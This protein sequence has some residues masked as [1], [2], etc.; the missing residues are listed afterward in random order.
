[1]LRRLTA[2]VVLFSG[3]AM[4]GAG[5]FMEARQADPAQLAFEDARRIEV[6]DRDLRG[7]IMKYRDVVTRYASNRAVAAIALVRLAACYQQLGQPEATA[8]LQRVV[9]DFADQPTAV[10]AARAAMSAARPAVAAQTTVARRVVYEDS[11]WNPVAVSPD[12]RFAVGRA[13]GVRPL[14]LRTLPARDDRPLF[15]QSETSGIAGAPVFSRD[16]GMAAFIWVERQGDVQSTSIGVIGTSPNAVPRRITPAVAGNVNRVYPVAWSA[17]GS[18][19]IVRTA[20][21]S[22]SRPGGIDGMTSSTLAWVS[23]ESGATT[24]SIPF[25]T[26]SLSEDMS[27]NGDYFAYEKAVIPG[28]GPVTE[29]S[30]YTIDSFGRNE[31]EVVRIAGRHRSPV[32]MPDGSAILFISNRNNGRDGLWAVRVQNGQPASEPVLIQDSLASDV[33]LAGVAVDGTVYLGEIQPERQHVFISDRGV[34]AA[35]GLRAFVGGDVGWS[36]DGA[37]IAFLKSEGAGRGNSLIIKNAATGEEQQFDHPSRLAAS[38]VRWSRDGASILV[39]VQGADFH[40]FD[41]QS[42]QFRAVPIA[43]GRV[44]APGADISPDGKTIYVASRSAEP[45][46]RAPFT[47]LVAVDVATG[48]ERTLADLAALGHGSNWPVPPGISVSPDGQSVALQVGE[49]NPPVVTARVVLV[50]TAG[51]GSRNLTG[52]YRMDNIVGTIAWTPDGQSVLYF[53]GSAQQGVWRLMKV[54]A[55]GGEPVFDG[56]ERATLVNDS[57]LPLLASYPPW[58]LTVSPDGSRV[59]FGIAAGR[60]SQLVALDYVSAAIARAR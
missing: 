57:S 10:A 37:S 21:F 41:V 34:P 50:A 25:S 16:G 40:I 45:S 6:I 44:R 33:R 5:S 56:L 29:S 17:D 11:E 49:A 52:P 28:T 18:S 9:R 20:Q 1:M 13:A 24:K 32:W 42:G 23:V 55:G 4:M 14:M 22:H 48:A 3:L 15:P 39:L 46:T 43:E 35:R 2:T 36:P 19:I 27:P 7:A 54:S 59:A 12:G 58:G 38:Q 31:T 30:I 51:S 60:S 26:E 53:T 8:T 47:Q